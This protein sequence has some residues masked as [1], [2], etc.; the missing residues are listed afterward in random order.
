MALVRIHESAE[1]YEL[2]PV[3]PIPGEMLAIA[4]LRF[5]EVNQHK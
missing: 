3:P 1:S 5:N 4:Q 2:Y